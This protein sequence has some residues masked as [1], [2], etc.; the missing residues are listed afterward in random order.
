MQSSISNGY[1]KGI[2]VATGNS[3]YYG[4]FASKLTKIQEQ[5]PFDKGI[6]DVSKLL[7]KFMLVMLPYCFCD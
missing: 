6:A 4:S 3:T 2:V 1:G 7:L 5:S